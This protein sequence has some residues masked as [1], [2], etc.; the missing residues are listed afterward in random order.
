ML[1]LES[2]VNYFSNENMRMKNEMRVLKEN[3]ATSEQGTSV[4][5]RERSVEVQIASLKT[6]KRNYQELVTSKLDGVIN[7]IVDNIIAGNKSDK[8]TDNL[9]QSI[10]DL[11]EIDERELEEDVHIHAKEKEATVEGGTV[12]RSC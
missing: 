2:N 9:D 4:T 7:S 12:W 11:S 10:S 1:N 3:P 5:P 8:V 6:E